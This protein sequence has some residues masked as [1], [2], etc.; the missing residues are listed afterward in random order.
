MKPG[1]RE[2]AALFSVLTAAGTAAPAGA[3]PSA[4]PPSIT[5]RGVVQGDVVEGRINRVDPQ[6]RTI[7]L[8]NGR[9]YLVP[10]PLIPDWTLLQVGVPVM[11][12]YNVDGGRNLVIYVEVRP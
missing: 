11:M 7:T 12:R 2:T 4:A 8:D 9:E 6:A 5:T 3:Q 1:V 10:P